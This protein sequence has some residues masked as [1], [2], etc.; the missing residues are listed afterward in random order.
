MVV[1]LYALYRPELIVKPWHI[2]ITYVLLT[3]SCAAV[4]IF[5]N[6]LLPL[7][8]LVG[9]VLVSAGGLISV[10]VLVAMPSQRATR[11]RVWSLDSF[12]ANNVT[13]WN[14][15]VAFILGILNGAF[16]I[17]TPDS[18]SHLAEESL[19]PSRD[20][21][22]AIATQIIL[23]T[24]TSFGFAIALF[25]GVQDFSIISSDDAFPLAALYLQATGSEAAACGLLVIVFLAIFIC[26]LGTYLTVGRM[27]WALARDNALPYSM[28]LG[29]VNQRLSCPVFSTIFCALL[30]TALG[31]V[32]LASKTAFTDLVGGFVALTTTSYAI[33]IIPHIANGR[34]QVP[35]GHFWLGAAGYT[36]NIL[37]GF[38]IIFFNIMFCFRECSSK[39]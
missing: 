14:D 34:S 38:L 13:G 11:A 19:D 20:L 32:Q 8:N 25:Y 21:P 3:W 36:I 26:I 22:R 1:Q 4:I 17:G 31:A 9:L 28:L 16:A 24:L 33:A 35:R 15:G 29:Q 6:K 39:K 5:A 27:L 10:V 30:C 2:Y 7:L 12:R 37:A 23:G 18:V